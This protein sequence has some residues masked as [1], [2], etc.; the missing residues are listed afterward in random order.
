MR[1]QIRSILSRKKSFQDALEEFGHGRTVLIIAHRIS[2]IEHA[3]KVIVLDAGKIV[4]SG[5]VTQLLATE[6]FS[7][8]ST[9]FNFGRSIQARSYEPMR[10]RLGETEVTHPLGSLEFGPDENGAALL[11]RRNGRPIGFLMRENCGQTDL[12]PRRVEPLDR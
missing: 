8:V 11:I 7:R 3:D 4:E 6:G 10:Y 1:R 5:S 9:R 2:T 12:V